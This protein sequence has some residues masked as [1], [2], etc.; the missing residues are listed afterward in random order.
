VAGAI[1]AN[2]VAVLIPCHRVIRTSGHPGGYAWGVARKQALIGCEAAS[3]DLMV[4]G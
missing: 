3:R 2:P 4:T 1:G